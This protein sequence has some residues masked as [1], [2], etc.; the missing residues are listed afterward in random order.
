MTSIPQSSEPR[1]NRYSLNL[2]VVG[3]SF[4]AVLVGTVSW[5][6]IEYFTGTSHSWS[7]FFGH[8]LVP[9]LVIGLII[10]VILSAL[11]QR[12]VIEPLQ[13]LFAHL[14]RVGSGRLD[15]VTLDTRI[16]EIKTMVD[17]VNLL[18]HRLESASGD[19]AFSDAQARLKKIRT[20]LR[21]MADGAGE[22]SS[23]F[24]DVIRELRAL[25]GD[26]LSL[27]VG[28]VNVENR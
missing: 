11:L 9:S 15:S 1:R 18:V 19:S 16:K 21:S 23:L 12:T 17:G 10:W 14:Y 28:R 25:E 8:H 7:D 22:D 20:E 5:G 27:G 2:V 24:L 26:L 13:Q 4:I 3:A 6:V